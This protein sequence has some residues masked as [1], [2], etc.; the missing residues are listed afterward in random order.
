MHIC[1]FIINIIIIIVIIEFANRVPVAHVTGQ[2]TA[3][4]QRGAQ[5]TNTAHNSWNDITEAEAND[6]IMRD[7]KMQ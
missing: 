3:C 6:Q 1:Q 7:Q 5:S 2:A 4:G